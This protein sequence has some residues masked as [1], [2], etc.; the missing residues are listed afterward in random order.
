A[1]AGHPRPPPGGRPRRPGSGA[2]ADVSG[3][4]TLLHTHPELAAARLSPPALAFVAGYLCH[5]FA[6][7]QWLLTVFR[8][9]CG[10]ASALGD[11]RAGAPLHWALHLLRDARPARRPAL[12]PE[13]RRRVDGGGGRPGDGG[14]DRHERAPDVGPRRRGAC[15]PRSIA[16]PTTDH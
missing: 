5:L 16:G 1:L 13:R 8:P 10:R 15:R 9:H 2:D 14:E 12:P 6:D 11:P 4:L 3:A 7:E